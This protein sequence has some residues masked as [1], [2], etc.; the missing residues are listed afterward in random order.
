MQNYAPNSDQHQSDIHQP[1]SVTAYPRNTNSTQIPLPNRPV[2]AK[3]IALAIPAIPGPITIAAGSDL[4]F[5][6][7]S[8]INRKRLGFCHLL[9][10]T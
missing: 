8:A 10:L 1:Q 3:R 6:I 2:S 7:R 5:E 4:R 9:R